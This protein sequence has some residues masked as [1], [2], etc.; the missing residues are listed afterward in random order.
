M[1]IYTNTNYLTQQ[2]IY[3]LGFWGLVNDK[4]I[5]YNSETNK[6]STSNN[7]I[8]CFLWHLFY[9]PDQF[10]KYIWTQTRHKKNTNYDIID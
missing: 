3:E 9:T 5:T 2:Q 4:Y 10:L 8:K 6:I 7:S 1:T